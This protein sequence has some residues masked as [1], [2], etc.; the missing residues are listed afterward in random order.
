MTTWR[1]LLTTGL[2]S[3]IAI[4]SSYVPPSS[5]FGPNVCGRTGS[6]GQLCNHNPAGALRHRVPV[7]LTKQQRQ[8][9]PNNAPRVANGG[10]NGGESQ[11]GAEYGLDGKWEVETGEVRGDDSFA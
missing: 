9:R 2:S 10:D 5:A 1:L 8:P 4:L 11:G 7:V 6:L 3:L